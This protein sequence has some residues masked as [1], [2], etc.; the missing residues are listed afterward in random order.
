[1]FSDRQLL[2]DAAFSFIPWPET[3]RNLAVTIGTVTG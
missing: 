3:A 1:M 2:A